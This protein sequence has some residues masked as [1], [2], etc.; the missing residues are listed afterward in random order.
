MK[1]VTSC[2][3]WSGMRGEAR[4]PPPLGLLLLSLRADIQRTTTT[5]LPAVDCIQNIFREHEVVRRTRKE[6]WRRRTCFEASSTLNTASSTTFCFVHGRGAVKLCTTHTPRLPA[7]PPPPSP[8]YTPFFDT[9][10]DGLH[11]L[12]MHGIPLLSLSLLAHRVHTHPSSG[13]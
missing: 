11:G 2:C 5:H 6:G 3:G 1:D 12:K 4:T 13:P 7:S 10:S 8:W 9:L